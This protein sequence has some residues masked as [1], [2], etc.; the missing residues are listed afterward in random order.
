MVTTA[1]KSRSPPDVGAR[2]APFKEPTAV[3]ATR[4]GTISCSDDAWSMLT[5]IAPR[6]GPPPSTSPIGSGEFGDA[7]HSQPTR[8]KYQRSTTTV[9]AMMAI[10]SG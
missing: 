1:A 8:L 7:G 4:L 6:L 3:P 5:W 2:A 9:R 10:A